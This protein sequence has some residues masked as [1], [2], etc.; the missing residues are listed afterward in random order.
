[1]FQAGRA[2]GG[3]GRGQAPHRW[4]AFCASGSV[5][6]CSVDSLPPLQNLLGRSRHVL[7][8]QL[9]FCEAQVG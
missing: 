7:I 4:A 1:M 6:L 3:G 8:L 2:R 9:R 5:S